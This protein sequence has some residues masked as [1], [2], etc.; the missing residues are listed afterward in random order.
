M[1]TFQLLCGA[2]GASAAALLIARLGTAVTAFEIAVLVAVCSISPA[3]WLAARRGVSVESLTLGL[4]APLT[5]VAVTAH[6]LLP[7]SRFALTYLGAMLVFSS[8]LLPRGRFVAL[9]AA[10]VIGAV[11]AR[12]VRHTLGHGELSF[13]IGLTHVGLGTSMFVAALVALE[14]Q[15]QRAR[16]VLAEATQQA[17]Q[18]ASEAVQATLAKTRFLANMSHELRTP[19]NAIIGYSELLE[20]EVDD[21]D[22]RRVLQQ[23]QASGTG[24]LGQI[25][26]VLETARRAARGD[27]TFD[28]EASED[29][30]VEGEMPDTLVQLQADRRPSLRLA[31]GG[32][33]ALAA[34]LSSLGALLEGRSERLDLLGG[35]LLLGLLV[36]AFARRRPIVSDA[37]LILGGTVLLGTTTATLPDAHD[38]EPYGYFLLAMS[39]LLFHERMFAFSV[40]FLATTFLLASAV[41]VALGVATPAEAFI[42]WLAHLLV[43]L[44]LWTVV[45][46]REARTR[47]LGKQHEEA[48]R[49][50]RRADR[51]YEARSRFLEQMS[52]EIR[53]PLASILGYAELLGEELADD[54]DALA[55]LHRI[56]GASRHL[57]RILDDVLDMAVIERGE[58]PFRPDHHTLLHLCEQAVELTRQPIEA[59]GNQLVLELDPT[60]VDVLVDARQITQI[61][62]NLLG[63]AAKFT[64]DGVVTLRLRYKGQHAYIEVAD[65]GR[66]ID[67]SQQERLFE[68]FERAG[69]GNDVAGT[70]LGLAIARHMAQ[71]HG[72]DLTVQS[73]PGRGSTFALSLPRRAT[74]TVEATPQR[75]HH[76]RA[77][78][79]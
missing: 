35:A 53:T 32:L 45:S 75:S 43:A 17:R 12:A 7:T 33:V 74:S 8:M 79:S 78:P 61:V 29:G 1:A 46:R 77:R 19:L 18:L 6:A 15:H 39:A 59:N 24:L 57:H 64:R 65:T 71:Q 55:D 76:A 20:E 38:L 52:R 13:A 3:L 10:T 23:M 31:A 16:R 5:A 50:R 66:G 2:M 72:G 9:G 73:A 30:S 41:R 58:I 63:N 14:G 4:M 34:F 22:H 70:G 68:P 62:V 44:P 36:A 28:V 37:L 67:P 56:A 25:D 51:A 54:E 48:E 47:Q 21:D 69:A 49:S 27:E 26:E 42:P 40:A 11:G 60:P